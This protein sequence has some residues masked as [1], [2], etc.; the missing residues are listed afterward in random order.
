V[1]CQESTKAV[2]TTQDPLHA[3][4]TINPYTMCWHWSCYYPL[5]TFY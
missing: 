1:I 2:S 5:I 3:H 4:H